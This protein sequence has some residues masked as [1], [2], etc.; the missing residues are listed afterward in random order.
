MPAAAATA[1]R[2]RRRCR[3]WRDG[4]ALGA[5]LAQCQLRSGVRSA[6]GE[7]GDQCRGV[8]VPMGAPGGR[9][10]LAEAA[11]D[12]TSAVAMPRARLGRQGAPCGSAQ[13]QQAAGPPTLGGGARARPAASASF[14]PA[15]PAV[16]PLLNPPPAPC[17]PTATRATMAAKPCHAAAA[18]PGSRLGRLAGARSRCAAPQLH[19]AARAT[20]QARPSARE[21]AGGADSTQGAPCRNGRGPRR[22]GWVRRRR[23]RRRRSPQFR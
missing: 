10:G 19:H 20:C 3:C 4:A 12:V 8:G 16:G 5:V 18:P 23:R 1:G 11:G 9:Q 17:A 21:A 2:R 15:L 13:A 6:W 7:T 22:G 14:P